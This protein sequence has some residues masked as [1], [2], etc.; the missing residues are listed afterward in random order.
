MSTEP[1]AG[2]PLLYVRQR[3]KD[4][5]AGD[6]PKLAVQVATTQRTLYNMMKGERDAKYSTVMKVY[7]ALKNAEAAEAAKA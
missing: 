6:L 4:M 7:K 1:L 3:L 2:D 5:P